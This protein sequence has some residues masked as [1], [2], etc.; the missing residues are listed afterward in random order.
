[1]W[2]K[3]RPE[4]AVNGDGRRSGGRVPECRRMRLPESGWVGF[5]TGMVTMKTKRLPF[6][7]LPLSVL[8]AFGYTFGTS[9]HAASTEIFGYD[10]ATLPT[11]GRELRTDAFVTL[12]N[13]VADK[14]FHLD[15]LRVLGYNRRTGTAGAFSFFVMVRRGNGPVEPDKDAEGR[16]LSFYWYDTPEPFRAP[17]WYDCDGGK[18]WENL[19][20]DPGQAFCFQGDGLVLET[21]GLVLDTAAGI[22]VPANTSVAVGNCWAKHV[23]LCEMKIDGNGRSNIA[24]GITLQT[25]TYALGR[26]S[27]YSWY[28]VTND[29]ESADERRD[30]GWYA[31]NGKDTKYSDKDGILF[32]MGKAFWVQGC[33]SNPGEPAVDT[34]LSYPKLKLNVKACEE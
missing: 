28:C 22:P 6:A 31:S 16:E 9:R 34:E 13:A 23:N 5:D 4:S 29:V 17:G 15:D 1:M 10:R 7:L 30:P 3:G 21:N 2:Q 14:T 18:R 33:Q 12:T 20:F 25:L 19:K 27:R 11:S 26:E 32:D 8:P 24:G